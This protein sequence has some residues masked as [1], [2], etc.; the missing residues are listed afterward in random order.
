[1]GNLIEK[2]TYGAPIHQTDMTT[3]VIFALKVLLFV[4]GFSILLSPSVLVFIQANA[5]DAGC[6]MSE[7]HANIITVSCNTN[8]SEI[9]KDVNNRSVPKRTL[10][11][12]WILKA[13]IKI[14]PQAKLQ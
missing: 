13:T 4:V 12:W 6:V 5:V 7:V 11:E 14:N 10:M 1:M 3:L 2:Y 8:L 9:D